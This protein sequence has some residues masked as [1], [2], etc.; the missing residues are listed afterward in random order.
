M[1]S[2]NVC[3]FTSQS[4]NQFEAAAYVLVR[5]NVAVF[6]QEFPA[7]GGA[8]LVGGHA[9]RGSLEQNWKRAAAIH[10]AEEDCVQLHAVA[11]GDHHFGLIEMVRGKRKRAN[12]QEA[13][14]QL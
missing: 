14:H 6:D 7:G 3:G 1:F 4:G 9:V 2:T 5:K 13:E 12:Q 8:G 11:H 10:R